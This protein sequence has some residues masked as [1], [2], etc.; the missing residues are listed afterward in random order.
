[1]SGLSSFKNVFREWS[2]VN[3]LIPGCPIISEFQISDA[4]DH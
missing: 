4:I 1:M 2:I 3:G